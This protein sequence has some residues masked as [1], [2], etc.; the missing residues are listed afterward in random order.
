M[1]NI[2]KYWEKKVKTG[3]LCRKFEEWGIG[4]EISPSVT[5]LFSSSLIVL[6]GMKC[7]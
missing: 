4:I 5:C 1:M 7:N 6:E 3:N 2:L